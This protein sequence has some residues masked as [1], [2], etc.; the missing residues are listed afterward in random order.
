MGWPADKQTGTNT[1]LMQSGSEPPLERGE[2]LDTELLL[3]LQPA[4]DVTARFLECSHCSEWPLPFIP[5]HPTLDSFQIPQPA[6][7]F[8]AHFRWP[9]TAGIPAVNT[10]RF[11]SYHL[12]DLGCTTSAFQTQ[13]KW[14]ALPI[15]SEES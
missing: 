8:L 5:C 13:E 11:P 2:R 4:L 6:R 14:G 9:V 3:Q 10:A 12:S 7:Q 15:C 1:N